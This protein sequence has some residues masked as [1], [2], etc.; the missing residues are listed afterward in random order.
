MNAIEGRIV[1]D[2]YS[3]STPGPRVNIES[4]R[5]LQATRI[6]LGKT[7]QQ[8]LSSLPLMYNVCGVAQARTSLKAIQG[9]LGI[10]PSAQQEIAREML[11][12]VE[13]TREH[14]FRILVDWPRLFALQ[15]DRAALPLLGQLIKD[16][17]QALF[18]QGQ[19]FNLDSQ[20]ELKEK[21][22]KDLIDQLRQTL[23]QHVYQQKLEDWLSIEDLDALYLWM[24][25]KT[26]PAA[27]S[28]TSISLQGWSSQGLS[29]HD[30]LP[31]LNLQQLLLQLDAG[32]A[33]EFIARPSWQG[34]CYETTSLSRQSHHPLIRELISGFQHSLFTRWMARLVEL[35]AIPQQLAKLSAQ[36]QASTPV[37]TTSSS[38]VQGL[39]ITE[40]ARGR[41]IHRVAIDDGRISQYQILAPTEW[42]FH[43]QGV[44]AE[45]LANLTVSRKDVLDTLARIMINAI[46]PCV[47]F[48][49]RIH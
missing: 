46:D 40:A 1:I 22:L 30:F 48:D 27:Q 11:V 32:D 31:E 12:L 24:K 14:L 43:P 17:K 7:P 47:D 36:L 38:E 28:L 2:L 23:E 21:N 35:A 8:V 25:Q 16:F 20:L 45:S 26:G 49:L 19:A 33:D 29:S 39:A 41:L 6:M 37:E 3:A 18:Y 34:H 13:N 4:S 5:P 15:V 10:S 42:N 44:I 9:C